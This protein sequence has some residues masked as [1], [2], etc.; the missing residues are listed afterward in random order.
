MM[1]NNQISSVTV[2]VAEGYTSA[3]TVDMGGR[4]VV[5][6]GGEAI[7]TTVR[8]D[9]QLII[10]PTAKST[11]VYMEGGRMIVSAGGSACQTEM[12]KLYA[13]VAEGH[14]HGKLDVTEVN[15]GAQLHV[16][17]GGFVRA[18]IVN[19]GG[20]LILRDGSRATDVL[21]CSGGQ[22]WLDGGDAGDVRLMTGAELQVTSGT[23][24]KLL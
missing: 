5:I 2:K 24:N 6:S 17:S 3:T 19:S 12:N 16:H 21:V 7:D 13:W 10:A 22:L 4:L 11:G 14:V 15:D 9:G 1:Y 23:L 18:T 20:T 8:C